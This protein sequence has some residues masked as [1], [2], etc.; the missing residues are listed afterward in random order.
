MLVMPTAP[1]LGLLEMSMFSSVRFACSAVAKKAP[2]ASSNPVAARLSVVSDALNFSTPAR[3]LKQGAPT[4]PSS[5]SA[6]WPSVTVK[7]SHER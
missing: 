4:S 6:P 7:R 2:L 5:R 3:S 1:S